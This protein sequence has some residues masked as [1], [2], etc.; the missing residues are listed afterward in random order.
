MQFEGAVTCII[1]QTGI[2]VHLLQAHDALSSAISQLGLMREGIA[3]K[4][5]LQLSCLQPMK[6]EPCDH[7][8]CMETKARKKAFCVIIVIV[9]S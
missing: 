5:C 9:R 8:A 3:I 2:L 6:D 1:V 7:L 4:V